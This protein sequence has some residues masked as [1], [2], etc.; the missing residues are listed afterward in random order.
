MAPSY[1]KGK[2]HQQDRDQQTIEISLPGHN[3]GDENNPTA[4]TEVHLKLSSLHMIDVVEE[5]LQSR[6]VCNHQWKPKTT[7]YGQTKK[8]WDMEHEP[9]LLIQTDKMTLRYAYHKPFK[10]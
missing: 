1:G 2:I 6:L 8:S 5:K 3:W 7:N 10:I 9:I 4:A